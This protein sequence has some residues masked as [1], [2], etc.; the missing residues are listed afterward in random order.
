MRHLYVAA[1]LIELRSV[2]GFI[3]DNLAES[4]VWVNDRDGFLVS[5]W[6]I[7][8][9][10][11]A[12]S[13]ALI[14]YAPL[15][16]VNVGICG[17]YAADSL[18]LGDALWIGQDTLADLGAFDGAQFLSPADLGWP[19]SYQWNCKAPDE[20]K[21]WTQA[22]LKSLQTL[23]GPFKGATVQS[24]TGSHQRS[25]EM[26]GRGFE[27]ESMEG[28]ALAACASKNGI[29]IVQIRAISNYA[30]PRDFSQWKITEALA[31][32]RKVFHVEEKI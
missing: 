26:Q 30:G 19:V 16:V 23:K 17:A 21:T 3:P 11:L 22:E 9:S 31:S 10:A 4:Q 1:S 32:L 13:Q 8:N 12:L 5:G 25:L 18:R 24:C 6:G 20:L 28:A 29:P 14:E 7:L 2:F 15:A 27:L